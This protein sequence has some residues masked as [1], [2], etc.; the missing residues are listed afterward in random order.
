ML[1]AITSLRKL[2]NHPKLIYDAL[3]R[4]AGLSG[5]GGGCMPVSVTLN[6]NL[7]C[8]PLPLSPHPHV[9]QQCAW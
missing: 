1:S 4:W 7:A 6:Q 5:M 3:H 8:R 2:L 9:P